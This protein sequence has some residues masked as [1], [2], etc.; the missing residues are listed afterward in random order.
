LSRRYARETLAVPDPSDLVDL[1]KALDRLLRDAPANT[2]V[3]VASVLAGNRELV[4]SIVGQS[5]YRELLR[6]LTE[7]GMRSIDL[8]RLLELEAKERR[9]QPSEETLSRNAEIYRLRN[10]RVKW[11]VI[12][13]RFNLGTVQAARNAYRSHERYLARAQEAA[14]LAEALRCS[15]TRRQAGG[16]AEPPPAH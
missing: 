7:L 13:H 10:D 5:H 15:P 16:G 4:E 11:T 14:Q 12:V 6:F 3:E 8:C 9:R 1:A 2:T